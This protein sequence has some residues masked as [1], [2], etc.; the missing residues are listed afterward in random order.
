MDMAAILCW[1]KE[2]T[3]VSFGLFIYN[4]PNLNSREKA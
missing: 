3:Y 4:K 1:A 2:K